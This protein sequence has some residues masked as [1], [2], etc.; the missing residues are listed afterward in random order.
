GHR[1]YL[2]RDVR[3]GVVEDFAAA[4]RRFAYVLTTE[5]LPISFP[6]MVARLGLP[7]AVGRLPRENMSC[8]VGDVD[9]ADIRRALVEVNA[10]EFECYEI[11]RQREL[12]WL[13]TECD[14]A[15]SA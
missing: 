7:V 15:V 1:E 13:A 4:L 12:A 5:V 14:G 6:R 8:A 9:F 2:K 3:R 11:V 10:P